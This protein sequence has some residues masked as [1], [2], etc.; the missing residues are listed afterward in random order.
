MA[1]LVPAIHVFIVRSCKTWM[2]ATSMGMTITGGE[3]DMARL[4]GKTAIVT[5]GAKGIGRHYSQALAA[6]G[7]RV[8][9][10]DIADGKEIAAEIAGRHGA[11]SVASITFDVSDETAV[12]SLVAQTI[13]SFGQIDILVNN[14]AL[15]ST[16][17]PRNFNEWDADL[18]SLIH[19]SEPTRQAEISY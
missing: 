8:M 4:E 3:P 9:I 11:N 15:Y 12:E 1:G 7:A 19:I 5:G 14:A 6:E 18:L 13:E 10:A 2:P 17:A 16:L